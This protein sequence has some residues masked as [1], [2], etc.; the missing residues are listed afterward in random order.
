MYYLLANPCKR[1]DPPTNGII[2]C[3][4]WRADYVQVC[5]FLCKK[6]YSLPPGHKQEDIYNCGASGNWLPKTNV[7]ACVSDGNYEPT[8]KSKFT[9]VPNNAFNKYTHAHAH[10]HIKDV[11][12]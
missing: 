6:G 7:I 10:I 9:H 11:H 12:I 4:D 8:K 1:M 5:K 3:N 2:A